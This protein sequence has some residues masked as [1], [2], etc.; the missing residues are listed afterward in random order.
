MKKTLLFL[1]ILILG[2]TSCT[3]TEYIEP[4]PVEN[5]NVAFIVELVPNDWERV[6]DAKIKVDIPLRDLTEYYLLQGNVAV[7]LSFDGEDSY[8][9]LPMTVDGLAY[10]VNYTIGWIT[11][12][13][14]DPLAEDVAVTP[15]PSGPVVAKIVLTAT[16]F[17][18]YQGLFN[19]PTPGV[20]FQKLELK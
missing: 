16:D 18:D 17:L 1:S 14:D 7:A 15:F 19:S 11:I 12:V 5:P 13:I 2:I 3:K 4:G 9:V 6:S 8:D 20:N 10:S